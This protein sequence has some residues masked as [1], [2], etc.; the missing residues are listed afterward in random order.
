ME[1][2]EN[3]I[4]GYAG[5]QRGAAGGEKG[6][7]AGEQIHNLSGQTTPP[8]PRAPVAA[9]GKGPRNVC[10]ERILQKVTGTLDQPPTRG[11]GA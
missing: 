1:H 9:E 7:P 10:H 5:V 6:K 11:G 3:V 2:V 4:A 8:T